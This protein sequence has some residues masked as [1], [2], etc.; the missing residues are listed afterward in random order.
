[1]KQLT[2]LKRLMLAGAVNLALL[3]TVL[4]I[5][6][7]S[8]SKIETQLTK[9]TEKDWAKAHWAMEISNAANRVG[10]LSQALVIDPARLAEYKAEI[11]QHRATVVDRLP[12]IEALIETDRGREAIANLKSNREA[13]AKVYPSVLE[14]LEA[15]RREEA[16]RLF[17]SEGL[18]KLQAYIASVN[19]LLDLQNERFGTAA[20]HAQSTVSDAKI[21]MLILALI[22]IVASV[23]LCSALAKSILGPLGGE[24]ADAC[25]IL[26]RIAAGDLTQPVIAKHGDEDSLLAN[27]AHMQV[28]LRQMV[29]TLDQDANALNES[30]DYLAAAAAQV[31]QGSTAQADSAE[32]MASAI[33]QLAV[34]VKQVDDSASTARTTT[35]STYT[36]SQTGADVIGATV[37]DM[38]QIEAIVRSAAQTV[39]EMGAHSNRISDVVLVIREVADQTNLLAL[40]AAIEAARAGEAGRG[41]AVVADEVRKLSERTAHATS[42]IAQMITQVQDSA[43]VTVAHMDKAVESVTAGVSKAR[44]AQSSMSS[45]QAGSESVVAAV[46]DISHSLAEQSTASE[47]VANNVENIAQMAEENSSAAQTTAQTARQLKELAQSVRTS[48]NWF[49]L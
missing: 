23:L 19:H 42:E 18:P 9:L 33:E 1:M 11:A 48:V 21:G 25:R 41:F 3:I 40:N 16:S 36:L 15:G 13:F 43:S 2:I 32:A 14:L 29:S 38:Y 47:L 4:L 46:H 17:Q 31:A 6:F 26:K 45:I 27:V 28:S 44:D 7:W 20:E 34:S 35:T 8:L 30:A 24:P 22:A 37:S 10:I 5:A 49:K 39:N 12:K